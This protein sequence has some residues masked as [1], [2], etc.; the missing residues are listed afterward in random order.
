MDCWFSSATIQNCLIADSATGA[1]SIMSSSPTVR[2]CHFENN[3]GGGIY[4]G[5]EGFVPLIDAC[6][7]HGNSWSAIDCCG[8]SPIITNCLIM[9]N[10]SSEVGGGVY[11]ARADATISNCTIVNNTAAYGAAGVYCIDGTA[12]VVNCVLRGNLPNQVSGGGT[13]VTFC[14]IEGGE[15]GEGNID[16]DPLFVDPDNHNFRI[17]PGS[18]C[19]DAGDS[20]SVP[21]GIIT[22]L[23]G[24][25]RFVDDPDTPDTGIGFPCVDMGAYEFQA[26]SSCPEDVNGD[27]IVNID[28]LFQV[29]SA[30]GA[31]DECPEDIN[32]DGTVDIDDI[33]EVL[34]NWGPC[35]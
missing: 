30:W 29:L 13:T 22:D 14:N 23:D 12:T 6:T 9:D 35:P 16:E 34:A 21:A 1:M 20:T 32:E 10:Q 19:I 24:N 7:F 33:F 26:D 5:D 17:S 31:C 4:C 8:S 18:P 3:A 25:A 27:E 28:D 2:N 15:P 11:V